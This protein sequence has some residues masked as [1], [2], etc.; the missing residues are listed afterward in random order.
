[1]AMNQT[2]L[3]TVLSIDDLNVSTIGLLDLRGRLAI[4]PQD[5]AMFEGSVRD[6]LDPRHVHD[7]TELWSV[8][9]MDMIPVFSTHHLSRLT[10]LQVMPD[11]RIMSP[12]WM[13]SSMLQSTKEVSSTPYFTTLFH[14]DTDVSMIRIESQSGSAPAGLFGACPSDP[15]QYF[16]VG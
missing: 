8:L 10:I 5:P 11:S 14:C 13:V 9:G 7:D 12:V 3:L 4:I 2:I 15:E 1:M 6:N 16:G